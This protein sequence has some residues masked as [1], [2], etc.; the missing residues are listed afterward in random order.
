[1]ALASVKLVASGRAFVCLGTQEYLAWTTFRN[2]IISNNSATCAVVWGSACYTICRKRCQC[3][4][5]VTDHDRQSRRAALISP[6]L[7]PKHRKCLG[8]KYKVSDIH[9][10]D[11]GRA[12]RDK[13]TVA[14]EEDVWY[15]QGTCNLIRCLSQSL[16]TKV[17]SR[18]GASKITSKSRSKTEAVHPC[19]AT[20]C[21]TAR[22]TPQHHASPK[23]KQEKS[24]NPIPKSTHLPRLHRRPEK[25][26]LQLDRDLKDP[27]LARRPHSATIRT[28]RQ[29]RRPNTT[30]PPGKRPQ[31]RPPK[32]SIVALL[33]ARLGRAKRRDRS[34]GRV[35]ADFSAQDLQAVA[36]ADEGAGTGALA[37][38]FDV[39]FGFAGAVGGGEG[40][41][42]GGARG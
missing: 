7:R 34:H 31:L 6:V 19:H 21:A 5:A 4:T 3:H 33:V 23:A 25:P 41:G 35:G 13:H 17:G 18:K 2:R 26:L 39:Q 28:H 9:P 32:H 30:F 40:R 15:D 27:I 8:S 24:L 11:P 36:L 16:K 20:P 12:W 29:P 1:M 38:D 37:G 42:G 14:K 10:K 22:C